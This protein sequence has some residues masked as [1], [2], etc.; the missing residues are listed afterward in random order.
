MFSLLGGFHPP[1]CLS[2]R[3]PLRSPTRWHNIYL[4]STLL[5]SKPST[6]PSPVAAATIAVCC[7]IEAALPILSFENKFSKPSAR[8]PASH[9]SLDASLAYVDI[10][11]T[12]FCTAQSAGAKEQRTFLWA[13]SFTFTNPQIPFF[14]FV[15]HVFCRCGASCGLHSYGV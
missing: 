7:G 14:F 4:H 13:A 15:C 6:L 8:L 3:K 2:K 11:K 5:A 1:T 10:R 9:F 12:F